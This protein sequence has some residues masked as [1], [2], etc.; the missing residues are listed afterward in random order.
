MVR[1]DGGI[2]FS[3][4]NS[5]RTCRTFRK[6]LLRRYSGRKYKANCR[7]SSALAVRDQRK[8]CSSNSFIHYR[9]FIESKF[10][11]KIFLL[12]FFTSVVFT[13]S[14]ADKFEEIICYKEILEKHPW[15]LNGM[16]IPATMH[17]NRTDPIGI[18]Y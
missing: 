1:V 7:A 17:L 8:A 13:T 14:S 10:C 2:V 3:L 16:H 11:Q 18:V 15:Y 6:G 4:T 5:K 12:D 9:L